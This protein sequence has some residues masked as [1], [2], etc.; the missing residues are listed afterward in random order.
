MFVDPVSG[1][2]QTCKPVVLETAG[3]P[4]TG[5]ELFQKVV[6]H[7]GGDD[8]P[9]FR[10]RFELGDYRATRYLDL[11]LS[12]GADGTRTHSGVAN[13]VYGRNFLPWICVPGIL[14]CDEPL[15]G[16]GVLVSVLRLPSLQDAGST[17]GTDPAF[18]DLVMMV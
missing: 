1:A 12:S 18:A 13:R 17:L 3:L 5:V 7:R 6:S 16:G 2:D 4:V 10:D 15:E 8:G 9:Y 11:G 14:Q